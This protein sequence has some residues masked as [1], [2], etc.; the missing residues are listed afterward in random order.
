MNR[1]FPPLYAILSAD[2][3][4]SPSPEYAAEFAVVLANSGVGIIQYRNKHATARALLENSSANRV[5]STRQIFRAFYRE[6]SPRYR[7][8]LRSRWRPRRP[9]RFISRRRS[10]SFR[11]N[12]SAS[13]T[14][15]LRRKI[16]C[17]STQSGVPIKCCGHLHP[18]ARPSPTRRHNLRR[19]RRHRPNL[20]HH[21]QTKSR[22]HGRS[23]LHPPSPSTHQKAVGSHWRN[24]DSDCLRS[25]PRWRRQHRHSPG[26]NLRGKSSRPRPRVSSHRKKFPQVI[27]AEPIL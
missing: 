26:S 1:E 16:R 9:R 13:R 20:R 7:A 21:H 10:R 15:R 27:R 11:E 17:V 25:I 22:T 14:F 24:H 6:R 23:R 8:P 2:L 18:H 19:L 5:R 4:S 12:Y 3:L